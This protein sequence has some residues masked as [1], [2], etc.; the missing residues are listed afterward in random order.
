MTYIEWAEELAGMI[1]K[2]PLIK[3]KWKDRD[4]KAM[5]DDNL[6]PKEA[7]RCWVCGH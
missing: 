3:N 6:T 5:Y 1:K 7:L 2:F 4:F